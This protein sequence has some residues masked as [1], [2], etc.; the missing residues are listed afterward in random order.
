[1]SDESGDDP[2][3]GDALI[4]KDNPDMTADL[5]AQAR[6][7]LLSYG[8]VETPTGEIGTMSLDRWKSFFDI[9]TGALQS[10][11]ATDEMQLKLAGVIGDRREALK[12]L[13]QALLQKPFETR[14]LHLHQIGQVSD[15]LGDLDRAA[16]AV[17][18]QERLK[19]GLVSGSAEDPT[20]GRRQE[21][22]RGTRSPAPLPFRP[23]LTTRQ[24]P[25]EGRRLPD[26]AL[27]GQFSEQ[28]ASTKSA[29]AARPMNHHTV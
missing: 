4:T 5:L 6:E 21:A 14:P 12:L 2:A 25:P 13:D 27:R 28:K 29:C 10:I 24:P 8:I 19:N 20:P 15:G 23:S 7:K 11:L 16:H 22:E 1:V 3:P 17:D 9:M 26:Q 18:L